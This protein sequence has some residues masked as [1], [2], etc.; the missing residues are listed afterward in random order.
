M[1][2]T[3]AEYSLKRMKKKKDEYKPK[4]LME[5]HP[6]E[7]NPTPTIEVP[8]N[9]AIKTESEMEKRKRKKKVMFENEEKEYDTDG[10]YGHLNLRDL[11]VFIREQREQKK[12]CSI[13]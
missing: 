12:S 4:T 10:N 5:Q 2:E 6:I 9:G 8:E 13:M 3:N 7:V 11:R 1:E